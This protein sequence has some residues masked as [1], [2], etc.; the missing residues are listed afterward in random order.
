M[1]QPVI[2][3]GGEGKRLW[4]VSRS[5]KPKQFLEIFND[6]C[7]FE[8]TLERLKNIKDIRPPII[9]TSKN[10]EFLVEEL[11]KK[12]K[13]DCKIFLEPEG[14]GTTAA[15]YLAS[16]EAKKNDTLIIL[17]SDHFIK[18]NNKFIK[19]I[20]H[21]YENLLV[22]YWYTFMVKPTF[23]STEYGYIKCSEKKL[24]LNNKIIKDLINFVEK[25]SY[26]IA[27]QMIS[28]ENYFW[29]SGIFMGNASMIRNSISFHQN[30]ISSICDLVFRERQ[31]NQTS[32]IIN[33]NPELFSKIISI[34]IDFG[35]LEKEKKIKC[36][37]LNTEWSDLGTWD[38][39]LNY[40]DLNKNKNAII[41]IDGDNKILNHD[42]RIIGTVGISD[43]LIVD[44]KEATLITKKNCSNELPNLITSLENKNEKLPNSLSYEKRPWGSFDILLDSDNYKV[45]KLIIEPKQSISLQYHNYRSEHW[46]VVS[47][48][49]NIFLD[50]KNKI[51]TEGQSID[52]PKKSHHYIKNEKDLDLI[53]IEVQMGEYLGEDDIIRLSDMYNRI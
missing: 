26:K 7:L 50:G 10:T 9:I 14:K 25:P 34:S 6:K 21:V 43:L 22:D 47:G 1:L 8:L 29:N 44:T 5:K 18:N 45:K 15:I 52:I 30:E 46:I 11:I 16:K 20:N 39:F 2:L 32:N 17:P 35:V 41:Q 13:V 40:V 36:I 12:V 48:T 28:S 24:D 38:S 31:F 4:P 49:A 27:K 3:C 23:A 51:M 19:L 33:F 53:I 42:N 37:D